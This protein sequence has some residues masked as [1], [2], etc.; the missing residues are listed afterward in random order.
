[1]EVTELNREQLTELK[2]NYY[3][4]LVNEGTFAE[5]IGRNYDEPSYEDLAEVNKIIPDKFIF[6]HYEGMN[7]SNDDFF[8]TMDGEIAA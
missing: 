3:T 8:C 6:E 2:C 4:E 1:M 7:F 5:V